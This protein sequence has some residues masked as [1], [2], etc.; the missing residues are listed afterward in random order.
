MARRTRVFSQIDCLPKIMPAANLR[1]HA[2]F[3]DPNGDPS[4]G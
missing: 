2:Y 3:E 1:R 4:P